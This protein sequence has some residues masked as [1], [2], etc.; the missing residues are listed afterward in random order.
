MN[1]TENIPARIQAEARNRALKIIEANKGCISYVRPEDLLTADLFIPIVTA[2]LPV[3][4]EFHE[5]IPNIGI[6]P[7]VPLMNRIREAAGVNITRTDTAQ[8]SEDVWVATSYGEKRMPDGTMLQDNAV[9]EFSA[10]TRAERDYIKKPD[11]YKTDIAKR[12][13][14]LDL[15]LFGRSKAETGAQLRLIA[16]LAKIDRSFKTEADLLRGMILWRVDRNVNGVLADPG[17]RQAAL[18]Q[19]LGATDAV[20]GPLNVAP[21]GI[22]MKQ[23]EATAPVAA[24]QPAPVD[25]WD[26]KPPE[27]DPVAVA[28]DQL[29]SYL[30]KAMPAKGVSEINAMLDNPEATLQDV[31]LLIDRCESYLQKRSEKQRRPA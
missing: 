18:G 5:F 7:K 16:K 2:I 11:D 15:R 26:E 20:F 31:S 1:P 19:M 13:H 28:K 24:E 29:R 8:E 6:M 30:Q 3:K 21:L 9:Y 12:K 25:P 23:E 14:L 17:L 10:K 22:E 27:P 4:Q